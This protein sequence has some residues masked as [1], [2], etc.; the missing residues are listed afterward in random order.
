M[1]QI[2]KIIQIITIWISPLSI[3]L[4]LAIWLFGSMFNDTVDKDLQKE[5]NG[6][7]LWTFVTIFTV[8]A[9]V[10]FSNILHWNDKYQTLVTIAAIFG[11][12]FSFLVAASPFLLMIVKGHQE[13]NA[14][15]TK[16][17]ARSSSLVQKYLEARKVLGQEEIEQYFSRIQTSSQREV[18]E[19]NK[20]YL[21]GWIQLLDA[22][23]IDPNMKVKRTNSNN[24][25]TTSPLIFYT[26]Y[27]EISYSKA[28]LEYGADP[29]AV[30]IGTGN[31]VLLDMAFYKHPSKDYLPK[32]DL[33]ASCGININTKNKEGMNAMN[34][35]N[36]NYESLSKP[37]EKGFVVFKDD[38]ALTN[39]LIK[40]IEFLA[41]NPPSQYSCMVK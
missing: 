38:A 25:S 13:E 40:K 4:S 20:A 6:A 14:N 2:P 1:S 35:L 31:T 37:N 5:L 23:L 16:E 24:I 8:L 18:D 27:K 41:K 3:L 32:I 11:V 19:I 22:K 26:I 10:V 39:E 9:L 7:V 34:Y 36:R 29:N 21:S 28:L 17:T 30:E 12:L 33:L 15:I